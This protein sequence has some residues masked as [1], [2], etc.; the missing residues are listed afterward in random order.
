MK[1]DK[2]IPPLSSFCSTFSLPTFRCTRPSLA[3]PPSLAEIQGA[4]FFTKKIPLIFASNVKSYPKSIVLF[5]LS[6]RKDEKTIHGPCF[7]YSKLVKRGSLAT[8][9]SQLEKGGGDTFFRER[10]GGK[11]KARRSEYAGGKGNRGEYLSQANREENMIRGRGRRIMTGIHQL[12]SMALFVSIIYSLFCGESQ[13]FATKTPRGGADRER[14]GKARANKNNLPRF[15]FPDTSGMYV[16]RGT[17]HTLRLKRGE[18]W[19]N[20]HTGNIGAYSGK[21]GVA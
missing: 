2:G 1:S 13:T 11:T 19:G 14:E 7:F 6:I 15:S 18:Y 9:T 16:P 17:R 12:F 4:Q 21:H 8:P 5:S 3:F 20:I 10:E